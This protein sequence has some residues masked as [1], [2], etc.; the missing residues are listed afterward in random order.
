MINAKFIEKEQD[1][2]NECTRYWFEFNGEE[3][4][5]VESGGQTAIINKDGNDI[6]DHDLKAQL[7]SILEV[8]DDMRAE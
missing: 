1:W 6:Y 2:Q 5:V 3:Y 4:A 7:K 8:T